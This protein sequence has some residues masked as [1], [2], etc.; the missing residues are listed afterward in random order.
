MNIEQLNLILAPFYL[1]Y[2]FLRKNRMWFEPSPRPRSSLD[3]RIHDN[4]VQSWAKCYS[5]IFKKH[6]PFEW[7]SMYMVRAVPGDTS[8]PPID[9]CRIPITLDKT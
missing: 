3:P 6:P 2:T 4:Q 5:N 1:L 8:I 7:R 9:P